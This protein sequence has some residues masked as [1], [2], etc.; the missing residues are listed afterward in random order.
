MNCLMN[1]LSYLPK[2]VLTAIFQYLTRHDM[3]C[4]SYTCWQ[5]KTATNNYLYH[6]VYCSEESTLELLIRT[7]TPPQSQSAC[8]GSEFMTRQKQLGQLTH[9]VKVLPDWSGSYAAPWYLPLLIKLSML[10]PNVHSANLINPATRL[11]T[12][13]AKSNKSL[14]TDNL[15]NAGFQLAT[16]EIID[17]RGGYRVE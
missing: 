10:T 12:S 15:A 3:L 9:I 6:K 14:Q 11:T 5:W 13:M 16:V 8:D 7:I 2:K 1:E 17:H 4:C